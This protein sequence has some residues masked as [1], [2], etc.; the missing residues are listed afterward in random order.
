MTGLSNVIEADVPTKSFVVNDD[1]RTDNVLTI[2]FYNHLDI[3]RFREMSGNLTRSNEYQCHYFALV[4]NE[5]KGDI[6]INFVF[7]LVYYNYKQEVSG[8]TVDFEMTDVTETAK[9]LAEL[10]S[11]KFSV[12]KAHISNIQP[13][14]EDSE[15]SYR[16]TF[17]NNIHKHP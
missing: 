16:T 4:R 3:Q 1:Y 17:Y 5:T 7:P 13:I 9:Q 8:A 15:V 12:M 6:Q 10:G 11:K 2:V 14:F